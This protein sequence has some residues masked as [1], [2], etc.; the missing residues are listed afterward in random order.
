MKVKNKFYWCSKKTAICCLAA[1]SFVPAY[2]ET[3]PRV[4][5]TSTDW[6]SITGLRLAQYEMEF[7]RDDSI[8]KVGMELYILDG[9]P[10]FGQAQDARQWISPSRIS[11]IDSDAKMRVT[12]IQKPS[13]L[14]FAW[15]AAGKD[16]FQSKTTGILTCYPNTAG[17][18]LSV[19]LQDCVKG[20][21]W[22]E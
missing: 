13:E 6:E 9:F 19:R 7:V 1:A 2:A 22:N 4:F 15:R 18:K 21:K 14:K 3:C 10:C 5:S 20:K 11:A 16:D 12:C 17:R 8:G